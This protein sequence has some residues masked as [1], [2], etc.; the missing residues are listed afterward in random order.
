[1][2]LFLG[3]CFATADRRDNKAI[4]KETHNDEDKCMPVVD[5]LSGN[6]CILF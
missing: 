3:Y 2:F 4:E 5:T 6:K 1:M